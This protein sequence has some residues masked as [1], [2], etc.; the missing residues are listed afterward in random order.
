MPGKPDD[1]GVS[2]HVAS[3]PPEAVAGLLVANEKPDMLEDVERRL[4][5]FRRQE[6]WKE[7]GELRDHG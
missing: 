2:V 5:D 6:S 7:L 3:V 1:L 4:V